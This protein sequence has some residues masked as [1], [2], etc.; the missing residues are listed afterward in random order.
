MRLLFL[1]TVLISGSALG[2]TCG[3][4]EYGNL[5]IQQILIEE[6]IDGDPTLVGQILWTS[7][8]QEAEIGTWMDDEFM[9]GNIKTP[10]KEYFDIRHI[11]KIN[12]LNSLGSEGWTAFSHEISKREHNNN[13]DEWYLKRCMDSLS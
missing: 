2:E 9:S 12:I 11:D 8:N 10:L 4:Y 7:W 6:E 13:V 3:G 5:T 1:L